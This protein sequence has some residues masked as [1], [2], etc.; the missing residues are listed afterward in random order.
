MT[1]SDDN[2]KLLVQP[3]GV[4]PYTSL[5]MLHEIGRRLPGELP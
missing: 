3:D 2:Q 4:A 1:A 5:P